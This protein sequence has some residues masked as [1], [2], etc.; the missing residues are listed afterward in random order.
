MTKSRQLAKHLQAV[1][2]KRRAA[3]VDAAS[4]AWAGDDGVHLA[5]DAHRALAEL[6]AEKIR[7]L[8][9]AQNKA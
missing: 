8:S 6:L 9:P 4:M 2:D 7:A 1:A 3:F 5:R